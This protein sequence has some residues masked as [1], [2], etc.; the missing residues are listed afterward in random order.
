V[1]SAAEHLCRLAILKPF[2]SQISFGVRKQ[3]PYDKAQIAWHI[4]CIKF[5]VVFS[6]DHDFR[7]FATLNA[8]YEEY[9]TYTFLLNQGRSIFLQLWFKY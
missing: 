1:N 5:Q 6:E 8:V 9:L 3:Q 2:Q 7:E 4:I